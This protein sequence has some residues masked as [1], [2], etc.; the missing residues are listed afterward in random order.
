MTRI[1]LFLFFVT[2]LFAA[3]ASPVGGDGVHVAGRMGADEG[4]GEP[5]RQTVYRMLEFF[6]CDVRPE[7][8]KRMMIGPFRLHG[9]V[10]EYTC[11]S[12]LPPF[13]SPLNGFPTF[14]ADEFGDASVAVYSDRLGFFREHSPCWR[15]RVLTNVATEV[16]SLVLEVNYSYRYGD[17]GNDG[18]VTAMQRLPLCGFY[19]FGAGQSAPEVRLCSF[20]A[21]DSLPFSIVC[22]LFTHRLG[23]FRPL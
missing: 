15:L 20:P 21:D 19:A 8:K 2:L 14:V 5:S 23:D 11:A 12:L 3:C 18:F 9:A 22:L 13:C 16:D 4:G 7:H 6:F 1:F 17:E 10:G